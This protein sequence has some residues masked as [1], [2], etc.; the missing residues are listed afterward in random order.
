MNWDDEVDIVCTGSGVAGLATAIAA[1][2]AGLDVFVSDA[3]AVAVEDDETAQY[4]RE[5]SQNLLAGA[6]QAP[7]VAMPA[8]V[9]DDLAPAPSTSRRV[10]PFIGS[11][12]QTWAATCLA[13]PY[14]FLYS[15]VSDRRAI[16][17]R[18]SR[19]EPF[20]VSP[21]GTV[22]TGPDL[23]SLVL[24]DWLCV[25]ACRRGID[26]S[27]DSPLRRIVFDEGRALGA[28]V[29]TPWGPRA[30]RARR[31]V[32]VSTGG[33]DIRTVTPC[34]VSAYTT[35]QVSILRRAPSRFGRIELVTPPPPLTEPH[36]ACRPVSRHLVDVARK[37]RRDRSPN[38]RCGELH[39]YPPLG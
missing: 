29:G 22:M 16:T 27:M 13:S 11:G 8:K 33:H 26:I 2:D 23:R 4:F 28:V 9:I 10:A 31:G 21:V 20:E 34:D 1:V 14:G 30:V 24:A 5:L 6:Q 32:L 15:R 35:L 7:T 36:T 19:D 25:Q 17:M 38:W 18:S 3:A 37:T 12:L 39:R